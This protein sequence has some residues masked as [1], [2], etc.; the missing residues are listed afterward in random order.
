MQL[1]FMVPATAS[2][3]TSVQLQCKMQFAVEENKNNK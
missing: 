3:R 1:E 2:A